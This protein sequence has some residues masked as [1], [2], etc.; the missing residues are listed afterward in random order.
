M[1]TMHNKSVNIAAKLK[2]PKTANGL[3]IKRLN[4]DIFY[5]HSIKF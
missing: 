2:I 5:I 1:M 3:N 4:K